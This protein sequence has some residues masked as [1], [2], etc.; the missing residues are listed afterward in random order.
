VQ[1]GHIHLDI[2]SVR[3]QDY[4][5]STLKPYWRIIVDKR[6]QMKFSD[7][8][9]SKNGMVEPTCQLV[10]NLKNKGKDIRIIRC[11]DGGENAALEK[12]MN[13]SDWKM[14]IKFEYTGR[15]TPQHNSLA[16]VAFHTIAS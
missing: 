7:F 9:S 6:T 8:F 12:Q 16:E 15:N 2:S 1:S 5:D 14:G 13:S 10:Q 11:N 4:K 3:N